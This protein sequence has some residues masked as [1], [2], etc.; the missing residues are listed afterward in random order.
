MRTEE[1]FFSARSTTV[2]R[3]T[4]AET[5]RLQSRAQASAVWQTQFLNSTPS[6]KT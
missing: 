3:D 4:W 2:E 1:L 6:D 5:L